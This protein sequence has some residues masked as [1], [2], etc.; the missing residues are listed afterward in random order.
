M[1]RRPRGL[2][3]STDE[4]LSETRLGATPKD[5]VLGPEGAMLLAGST[6]VVELSENR[7]EARIVQI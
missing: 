4:Q 7:V 5:H 6:E 3:T 2:S 1:G